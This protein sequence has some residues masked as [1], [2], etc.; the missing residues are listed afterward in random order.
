MLDS[1][2]DWAV[3]SV[4]EVKKKKTVSYPRRMLMVLRLGVNRTHE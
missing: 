2:L 1:R 3:N 4:E